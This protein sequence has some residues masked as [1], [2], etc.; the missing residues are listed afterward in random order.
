MNTQLIINSLFNETRI[1]VLEKSRLIELFIERKSSSSMVGNIYKGK[2]EKIVPGVQAAFVGMG[3]GKSGFLSAEDVYEESLSELFLEEEETKKSSR[4][5]HQPIQKVLRQG[6]EVM[7]QVTKEPTGNKGPKLTSH[8]GIPGKYLVLLPGSDSVNL[9][10]KITDRKSR[11][12][13]SEIMRNKPEDMG[14]IVRT[15]CVEADEKD[16]KSEM[17]ALVRKWRRIKKKYEESKNPG[18]IYE[19]SDTCIRVIR[20]L[21]GNGLKKIVVD[22][23]KAHGR[24]TKYFSDKINKDG[25]KVDMY[26]KE[27]P[28]FDRYGIESQIE[29]MYR[30][31]AWMKSGGYLIID[32]AEG[33]TVI[34]VNSGKLVGEEFQ[35]KTIMKT[36]EEAAVEAARQIRLRN[37]VGIIVID[38]IDMQSVRSRKKVESLFTNEMKK[39]KAR[40]T[41]QEISSFS[42]IQLTRRRV[43]ESILSDLTEPCDTCEGSGRIKSI[44][45]TCYEILR[46]IDQWTRQ[47]AEGPLVVQANKKVIAKLREIEGRSMRIIQRERGVKIKFKSAEDPLEKYAISR[48]E[49]S[50]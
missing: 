9:S 22:S 13:F 10:R 47:S 30:K 28:I 24:I 2:V 34:D 15:A 14:F 1:A 5:N 35:K 45:T 21:M 33:L 32:E 4:K 7:V 36:N 48:E 6:Q 42:V 3:D 49:A 39:D 20:D 37:L 16:I 29:K 43:R 23:P 46:D 44:Y 40:T 50:G 19:E 8:V 38:F 26:D 11:K 18:A 17:R 27:E 25:F 31:K 41:I 12:R